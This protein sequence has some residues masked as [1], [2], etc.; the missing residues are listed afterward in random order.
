MYVLFGNDFSFW[1][2][3]EEEGNIMKEN[4]D[5]FNYK[6]SPNCKLNNEKRKLEMKPPAII[7]LL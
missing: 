1:I 3:I 6:N 2:E 5:N 7:N 4:M